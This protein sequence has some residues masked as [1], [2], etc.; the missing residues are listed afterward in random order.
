MAPLGKSERALAQE[1]GVPPNRVA[2]ILKGER[3][4]TA[5][6]AILLSQRFGTSAEFW[7]NLQSAHDL[8]EAR[9]R[10]NVAA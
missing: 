6:T 1:I 5:E 4:I 7:V 2:A 8:E 9:N 10:M 3:A